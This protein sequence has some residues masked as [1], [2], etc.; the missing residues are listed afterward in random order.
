M[1]QIWRT[2]IVCAVVMAS[3]V[4]GAGADQ[5][6]LPVPG[7]S[8]VVETADYTGDVKDQIVRL[9]GHFTIRTMREGWTEIPLTIQNATITAIEIK[10]KTGEAHIVPRSGSYVLVA[11]KKGVYEV[12]VKFSR[13]LVQENQ[14]EALRLGIPQATFSTMTLFVPRKDVE[15]RQTDQLYVEREPDAVRGGVRLIARLGAADHVDLGWNTRP[16]APEKIDPVVYGEVNTLVTLEDQ[17]ARLSTIILYR[18]AQ[19]Q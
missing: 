12:H 5:M 16:S 2:S 14:V 3:G 13:L 18:M 8:W 10:R 15:L 19:V 1:G 6:I 7:T 4:R 11:T 9:E 17:L